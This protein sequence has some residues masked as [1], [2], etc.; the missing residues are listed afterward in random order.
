M[1]IEKLKS[2]EE[3]LHVGIEIIQQ[4]SP[5]NEVLEVLDDLLKEIGEEIEGKEN[6]NI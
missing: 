1:E 6:E 4:H 2:Y 3:N 5:N